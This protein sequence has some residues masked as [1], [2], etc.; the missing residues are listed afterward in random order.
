MQSRGIAPLLVR[1]VLVSNYRDLGSVRRWGAAVRLEISERADEE[2]LA[3][4]LSASALELEERGGL[5][6]R[7]LLKL[8]LQPGPRVGEILRAVYEQ[9]L[10]GTV[11]TLD[12]AIAAAKSAAKLV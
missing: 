3:R 9:Q 7:H 1:P 10:D 5:L 4:L 11:T 6:G 12:E 8:G 2:F